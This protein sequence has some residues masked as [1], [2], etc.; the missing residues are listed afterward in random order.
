MIVERVS[1]AFG[2]VAGAMEIML[3]DEAGCGMK[4]GKVDDRCKGRAGQN[5]SRHPLHR[6]L[7]RTSS[8][9][10]SL[11]LLGGTSMAALTRISSSFSLTH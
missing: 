4:G 9:H 3:V 11:T 1:I 8:P 2:R 6:T 10:R 7:P 5:R